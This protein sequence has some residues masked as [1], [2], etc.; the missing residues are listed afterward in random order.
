MSAPVSLRVDHKKRMPKMSF[1]YAAAM[2][3]SASSPKTDRQ[4]RYKSV[5]VAQ[6]PRN[7]NVFEAA[8]RLDFEPALQ[9]QEDLD[10]SDFGLNVSRLQ[11]QTPEE[12]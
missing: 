3:Y 7:K 8:P 5:G 4:R 11:L 2:Q 10:R 6:R 9:N 12:K 1:P